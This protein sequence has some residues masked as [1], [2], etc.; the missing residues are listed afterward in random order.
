MYSLGDTA[1]LA[2]AEAVLLDAIW[3]GVIHD[4][5]HRNSTAPL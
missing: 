5:Q 3:Q 1:H 4:H 2:S